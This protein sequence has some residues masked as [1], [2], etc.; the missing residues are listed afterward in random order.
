MKKTIGFLLLLSLLT[1]IGCSKKEEPVGLTEI[2]AHIIDGGSPAVD[3]SGFYIRLDSTREQLV[4]LNV[5]AGF[6]VQGID[7]P[8]LVKYIET[9]KHYNV[10]CSLC[11]DGL[12]V[13][14]LVSIRRS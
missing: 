10:D 11:N 14:Y 7:A 6:Q 5:P 4:P 9:G 3:G 1:G 13:V 2:K 12:K 8:V